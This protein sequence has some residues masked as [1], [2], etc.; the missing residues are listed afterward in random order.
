MNIDLLLQL[1]IN[2]VMLGIFYAALTLGFSTIW[3]VMRLVNLAHGE[4]LLMAAYVSWFFYNPARE[5][6]LSIG[7][8]GLPMM[9]IVMVGL[10]LSIGFVLSHFVLGRW[11]ANRW[12]RRLVCYGIGAALV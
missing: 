7:S 6:N 10:A 5:Q 2:G 9:L 12:V 8:G 4:F 11:L 1:A 3:G